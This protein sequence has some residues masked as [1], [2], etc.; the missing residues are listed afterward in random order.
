MTAG[1]FMKQQRVGHQIQVIPRVV[2][3]KHDRHK[4]TTQHISNHAHH[5]LFLFPKVVVTIYNT[6]LL[7]IPDAMTGSL[8]TS[9]VIGHKNSS[10]I[11]SS[12]SKQHNI[13]N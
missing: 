1:S 6:E 7:T 3:G 4:K 8:I 13:K 12:A 9:R 2:T 10:S 5:L 11:P